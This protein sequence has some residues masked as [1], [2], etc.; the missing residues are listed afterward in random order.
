MNVF[1]LNGVTYMVANTWAELTHDQQLMAVQILT[2]PTNLD[3]ETDLAFKRVELWKV[4][5]GMVQAGL[6]IWCDN[7]IA[8]DPENGEIAFFA[9][10]EV[11][12][13]DVTAFMLEKTDDVVRIALTLY[14]NPFP[15][16]DEWM[17]LTGAYLTPYGQR[18]PPPSDKKMPLKERLR[19]ADVRLKN[20][21]KPLVTY[22]G[23][24]E[25]CEDLDFWELIQLFQ[26]VDRFVKTGDKMHIYQCIALL[27]RPAPQPPKGEMQQDRISLMDY[28]EQALK[29]ADLVARLPDIVV[30]LAWFY[31][32]SC[33]QFYVKSYPSVFADKG[34]EINQ[35]LEK[36]G[37][38]G[39]LMEMSGNDVTKFEQVKRTKAHDA[40]AQFSYLEDKNG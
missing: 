26:S 29:N 10:L 8:D 7:Y 12:S 36:Y 31:L 27:W 20:P 2:M 19:L 23:P 30:N 38:S 35:K 24:G 21:P 37:W 11:K 14:D 9:E 6:D 3:P 33:H 39:V 25:Q 4:V 34:G 18:A 13:T 16:F 22:Y 15:K 17:D 5:M 28:E 40:M 1:Q 32:C